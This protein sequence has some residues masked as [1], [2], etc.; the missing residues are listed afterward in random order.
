[1]AVGFIM[2]VELV[3]GLLVLVLVVGLLADPLQALAL[4]LLPVLWS[5][6]SG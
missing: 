3:A 4:L 6:L 1:L 2:G 5:P